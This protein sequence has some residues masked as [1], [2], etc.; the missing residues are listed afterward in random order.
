MLLQGVGKC[1]VQLQICTQ[2]SSFQLHAGVLHRY[3]WFVPLRFLEHVVSLLAPCWFR[4]PS[5]S[6]PLCLIWSWPHLLSLF[7]FF[8]AEGNYMFCYDFCVH[9]LMFG[10]FVY[11]V[12][13]IVMI[14]GFPWG[15][16]SYWI[17]HHF[18]GPNF[19]Y[20]HRPW[21]NSETPHAQKTSLVSVE[22]WFLQKQK[23]WT[24]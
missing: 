2:Q 7:L 8:L 20:L 14:Y 17:L 24:S 3:R 4:V 12:S 23:T 21:R 1:W 6:A 13:W 18:V 10:W 9:A 5:Y 16:H 19:I 11:D 22:A 15:F